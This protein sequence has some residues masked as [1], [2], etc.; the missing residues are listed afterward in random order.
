MAIENM[1]EYNGN[2]I[3]CGDGVCPDCNYYNYLCWLET[4]MHCDT[5]S[6]DC[7]DDKDCPH[8]KGVAWVINSN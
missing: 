8:R 7:P 3:G 6:C 5:G 1:C 2:D 4:H